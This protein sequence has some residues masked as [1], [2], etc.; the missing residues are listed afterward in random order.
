MF[1]NKLCNTK[2]QAKRL[3]QELTTKGYTDQVIKETIRK[4]VFESCNKFLKNFI[5]SDVMA[6]PENHL[7]AFFRLGA[8]FNHHILKHKK[9]FT[10]KLATRGQVVDLNRKAF[11]SQGVNKCLQFQG[12]IET[13]GAGVSIIKQNFATNQKRILTEEDT[14]IKSKS[15]FV[16]KDTVEHIEEL[17]KE[18]L[19][20]AIGRCVDLMYCI[21]ETSMTQEKETFIFTKNNRSKFL[22]HFR[23]LRKQSKPSNADAAESILFGTRSSRVNLDTFVQY[24]EARASMD[25]LLNQYYENETTFDFR[26]D[27]KCNLYY[28]H[29]FVTKFRCYFLKTLLFQMQQQTILPFRKTKFSSK[30][31]YDQN[32]E[33]LVRSLKKKL[34]SDAILI[35]GNWL[36][37]NNKF[38]EPTRNKGYI[39]ILKKNGFTVYLI[40]E[41]KTSPHCP[42]CGSALK[43]FKHIINPCPYRR[44]AM[45]VV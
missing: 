17:T 39:R 5:F 42:Q 25:G 19:N 29:L 41:R 15:K 4:E 13:D 16:N 8:L 7:K 1:L 6:N 23:I 26:V 44:E 9:R 35:F 43:K 2:E 45:P 22:R 18:N 40:N 3:R 33:E 24:I 34:G 38:Q 21:K 30:I 10:E 32:D 11:K 28:G 12:T 31:Y 37:P 20:Q 36:A 27:G 14:S